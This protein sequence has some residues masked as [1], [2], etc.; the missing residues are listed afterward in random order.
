MPSGGKVSVRQ[1]TGR[2]L[3]PQ[4]KPSLI[5]DFVDPKIPWLRKLWMGRLSIYKAIGWSLESRKPHDADLFG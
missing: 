4:D 1:Q 2:V 5:V 3:R